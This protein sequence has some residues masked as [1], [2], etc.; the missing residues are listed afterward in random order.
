[1]QEASPG[2]LDRREKPAEDGRPPRRK[3]KDRRPLGHSSRERVRFEEPPEDFDAEESRRPMPP[4]PGQDPFRPTFVVQGTYALHPRSQKLM[5]Y[6]GEHPIPI[7][8]E[9]F[10]QIS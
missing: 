3:P 6:E 9:V 10:S 8:R 4:L 1:M 2:A 5:P 7:P